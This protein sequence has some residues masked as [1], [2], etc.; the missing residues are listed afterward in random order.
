MDMT[1]IL[2]EIYRR[3]SSAEKADELQLALDAVY[4]VLSAQPETFYKH[5]P[6]LSVLRFEQLNKNC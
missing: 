6:L 3:L 2:T 1:A 4:A 5:P